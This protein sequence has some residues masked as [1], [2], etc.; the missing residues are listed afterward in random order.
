VSASSP[1]KNG[2][3]LYGPRK[4]P[5]FLRMRRR[6]WTLIRLMFS[7]RRGL[8]RFLGITGR[9][10]PTALASARVEAQHARRPRSVDGG[11][12]L[13]TCRLVEGGKPRDGLAV[14]GLS[15]SPRPPVGHRRANRS[16]VPCTDRAM[17]IRYCA[18][19][20]SRRPAGCAARLRA[21]CVPKRHRPKPELG[22]Q[23]LLTCARTRIAVWRSILTSRTRA[24]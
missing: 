19:A 12:G 23:G 6:A 13:R 20:S 9:A 18:A 1:E 8:S 17:T 3:R 7:D 4:R 2:W 5:V 24:A 15:M 14:A 16:K 10:N 11:Y 22:P 21:N